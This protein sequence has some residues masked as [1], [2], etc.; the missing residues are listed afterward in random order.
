MKG[1]LNFNE[2]FSEIFEKTLLVGKAPIPSK[3]EVIFV[4]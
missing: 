3:D 2:K 4:F 1:F